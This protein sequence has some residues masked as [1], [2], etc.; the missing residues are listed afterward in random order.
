MRSET[1]LGT[2][3]A[4]LTTVSFDIAALELFLPLTVGGR[5][6]IASRE[7]AADGGQLRDLL[8]SS[9][10]TTLQAT[11]ATWRL[12]L[13]AGWR[14]GERPLKMLCGGEALSRELAEALMAGGGV[15]WNM[16]GPTE[17][18]VWSAA[19]R[20]Y[21]GDTSVSGRGSQHASRPGPSRPPGSR[22]I[23]R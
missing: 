19:R 14:A 4:G 2:D 10:I 23:G 9:A 16:Y 21:G 22:R 5:V 11:P 8:V 13:E 6:V 20:T 15:L 17:T 7:A 12:L 18:T 1:G 3:I